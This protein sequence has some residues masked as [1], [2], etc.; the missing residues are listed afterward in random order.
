MLQGIQ[1]RKE[2]K[3]RA[4]CKDSVYMLFNADVTLLT[5]VAAPSESH[6]YC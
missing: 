2:L 5:S 3:L 1:H 6:R 4:L